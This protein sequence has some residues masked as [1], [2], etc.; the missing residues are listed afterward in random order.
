M[1]EVLLVSLRT[2]QMAWADAF[3]TQPRSKR[4]LANALDRALMQRSVAHNAAAA[5][6][7]AVKFKL[8]LNEDQ[9][10]RIRAGGPNHSGKH[11]GHGNERYIDRHERGWLRNLFRPEI[12]SIRLDLNYAPILLQAPSHLLRRYINRINLPRA[13]L[14]KAIRKAPGGRAD[15]DADFS[16]Y[17]D[18][19]ILKRAFQFESAPACI[20]CRG[21]AD[22]DSR[23]FV[24]LRPGFFAP[25]P[26][27]ANFS[28]KDHGLRFFTG[29]GEASLDDQH[30]EPLFRGFEL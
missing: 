16:G 1:Q 14:Q 30:I 18:G 23:F 22:F 12:S 6:I 29:F 28:R 13:M 24:D 2:C 15:I 5:D 19:E 8:W 25:L 7:S 17:V 3:D 4:S 26:V 27:H 11:L 10:L 9:K 21:A 20:F